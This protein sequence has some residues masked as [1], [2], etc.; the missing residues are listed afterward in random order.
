MIVR[1]LIKVNAVAFTWWT[2]LPHAGNM[3]LLDALVHCDNETVSA[4]WTVK[5]CLLSDDAGHLPAFVGLE[6]MAQNVAAWAGCAP[7]APGFRWN[8]GF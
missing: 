2:A 3:I 8:W 7:N 6:L 4:H 1:R 5:P